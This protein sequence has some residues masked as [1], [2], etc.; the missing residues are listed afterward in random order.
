[1]TPIELLTSILFQTHYFCITIAI[2]I[3][4]AQQAMVVASISSLV[5]TV[6]LFNED[7]AVAYANAKNMGNF[8][9]QKLGQ[10]T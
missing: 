9:I 5:A 1:M 8:H 3:N 7:F 10:I 6:R 4:A 2:S